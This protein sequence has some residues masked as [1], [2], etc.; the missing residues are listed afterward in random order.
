MAVRTLCAEAEFFSL[1]YRIYMVGKAW[2]SNA[3]RS[4]WIC[5]K[6]KNPDFSNIKEFLILKTPAAWGLPL[7]GKPNQ[8]PQVKGGE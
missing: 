1:C 5:Q 7:K 2:K 3:H 6:R 8:R 4:F